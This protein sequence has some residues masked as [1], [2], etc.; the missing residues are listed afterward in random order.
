MSGAT[1][2]SLPLRGHDGRFLP[3]GTTPEQAQALADAAQEVKT[4]SAAVRESTRTVREERDLRSQGIQLLKGAAAGAALAAGGAIAGGV[5][6]DAIGGGSAGDSLRFRTLDVLGNLP[7]IG[8]LFQ[9]VTNPLE[10]A[11]NET[12]AIT[13]QIAA[14]GGQI[15][16]AN[17]AFLFRQRL[18]RANRAQDEQIAVDR[19]KQ[20]AVVGQANEQL[21]RNGIGEAVDRSLVTEAGRTLTRFL[22][23]AGALFK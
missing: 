12:A 5:A 21:D 22:E 7:G 6:S 15:D 8:G 18:G 2:P 14:A 17:R 10:Q 11:A 20:S 3:R 9:R 1:P 19:M 13:T 23:G 16:D 4:F